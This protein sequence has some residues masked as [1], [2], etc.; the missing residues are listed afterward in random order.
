MNRW[1]NALAIDKPLIVKIMNW[2]EYVKN[3]A[4]LIIICCTALILHMRP[5]FLPIL[6]LGDETI[7]IGNG[8][9]IYQYIDSKWHSLIQILFWILIGLL[10]LIKRKTSK[11]NFISKKYKSFLESRKGNSLKYPFIFFAGL[12]FLYFFLLRNI[13]YF[14]GS[15]RYPPL[16]KFIYF[17]AYSAFG[18]NHIFPRMI[19]LIFN[20]LCAVYLYRTINLFHEKEAA[21]LGAVIYLFLPV[22]FL[23]AHLGELESG[24]IFFTAATSFY[25]IRFIKERDD[26]DLLLTVYLIGIGYLYKE[27][28]FLVFPA[29][30]I[31]LIFQILRKQP[32]YSF[33]HLKI[34]TFSL[35]PVIPWMIIAKLFSWRN[36]TFRLSNITTLDSKILPYFSL[37]SSNLS[38]IVFF[39]F[40]SS[41]LYICFF[42]RN[43]LTLFFGLLFV[44]YYFFIVSDVGNLS[45]RF[46]MAF[47]PTITIFISLFISGIIQHIKWKHAFKFCI[48]IFAAYLIVI[49]SASAP[50]NRHLT[51]EDKKLYYYPSEEAMKWVKEDVKEGERVLAIRILSSTFYRYKHE[52][53]KDKILDLPYDMEKIYTPDKLRQFIREHNITYIMFPYSAAYIK[54]DIRTGIL[55]YLKHN[56][57]KEFMKAAE[58]H[59][60]DKFIYIYKLKNE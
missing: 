36:Y 40:I 2:R 28:V 16:S 57:S 3:N 54:N 12:L 23:Y 20:L 50:N 26:R 9:W 7:H 8:L 5:L 19:Q 1:V 25:F 43:T 53:D 38:E 32:L 39:I 29:C 11:D 6:I 44:I 31:F 35:A 47:Y 4:W 18:I 34:L 14:P 17:I 60:D 22:T 59:I 30:F 48:I 21:L 42:K 58:F 13:D 27:A 37:I 55:E 52:I 49:S 10:I 56:P 41:V 45:P 24:V 15:I 46:S 51:G 33:A